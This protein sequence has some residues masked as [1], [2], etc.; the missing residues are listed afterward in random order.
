MCSTT[1]PTEPQIK[2][3]PELPRCEFCS[4]QATIQTIGKEMNINLCGFDNHPEYI[5][6]PIVRLTLTTAE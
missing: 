4:E 5:H 3:V 2:E 6:V 1:A